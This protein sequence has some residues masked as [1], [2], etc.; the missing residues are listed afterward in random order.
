MEAPLPAPSHAVAS[1]PAPA[2][3]FLAATI[4]VL[5][6]LSPRDLWAPDAP[7]YGRIAHEMVASGDW[8]VPHLNGYAYPEKPPLVFWLQATVERVSG[9]PSPIGARLP[10]AILAALAVLLTARIARRWFDDRA[11]GDTAGILFA[12]MGLVLWNGSWGGLDLPLTAFALLALDGGTSVVLHRSWWG[13]LRLGLGLGLGFLT[14]GPHALY[15]PVGAI[16][17]GALA[18]GRARRLLD[19]RLFLGL[20]LGAGI[21]LAWLLPAL[22]HAGNETTASGDAYGERLLGQIGT[23]LSGG[24]EPHDHP[25]WYLVPVL[26]AVALPWTPF[27]AIGAVAAVKARVARV[28]D[29]FGLGAALGGIILPLVLLSVPT[30]KRELYLIPLLPCIAALAAFAMHRLEAR[31]GVRASTRGIA[32]ALA[33]L[34]LL[35]FAVPLLAMWNPSAD[36]FEVGGLAIMAV[37][38]Y[39]V[40]LLAAWALATA[41]AVGAFRLRDRPAGAARVAAVALAAVYVLASHLLLPALDPTKS[42]AEVAAV[43]DREAPEAPFVIAGTSDVS[44]LWNF[45]RDRATV[46]AEGRVYA[47]LA[48]LLTLRG[49]PVVLALVK[50]KLWEER[51]KRLVGP[52][53][54]EILEALNR[55]RILWAKSVGG[56]SWYLLT[57]AGP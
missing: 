51:A 21:L 52:N 27:A 7:R 9:D 46:L 50:G 18:S 3:L 17:G 34:A 4:S 30:S 43:A 39:R 5:A 28:E 29:R 20:L 19:P 10:S 25:F 26:L 44:A 13:A 40:A 11:L 33:L 8:L 12:T 57:N 45:K 31:R 6:A 42:F 22:E 23:R 54:R 53:D 38:S 49:R 55:A 24:E 2:L 15:V 47:E 16:L 41:G 14:K 35:A 37:G 32:A 36:L 56:S 1:R 48:Q